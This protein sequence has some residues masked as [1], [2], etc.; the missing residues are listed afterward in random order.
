M[1]HPGA[2]H[3]A[4]Y[5]V[6]ALLAIYDLR[7]RRLPNAAVAAFAALY[8]VNAATVSAGPA[9]W[10]L[11]L[12]CGAA[13]LIVAATMFRFG[14]LGG[15]DVKLG[16]AVFLWAGSQAWPVF[17]SVSLCGL[18]VALAVLAVAG[19]Q[20]IPACADAGRWCPWLAP[21]RGVP[22]GVAL[23]LGGSLAVL[24]QPTAHAR[25]ALA[26]LASLV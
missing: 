16:A 25:A 22:Y 12:A 21:A 19:L 15:G 26:M 5:G 1:I 10:G 11:H 7:S 6:L 13:A 8:F 2:V 4:A 18:V 3:A 24:L 17:V 14:W 23:A 20:R 9:V